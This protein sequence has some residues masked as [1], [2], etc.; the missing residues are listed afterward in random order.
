MSLYP[1]YARLR[2]LI[3]DSTGYHILVDDDVLQKGDETVCGSTLYSG[4]EDWK[5]MD[6]KE[7]SSF[8]G[9]TVGEMNSRA[10]NNEMDVEERMFRR[11]L[12][13]TWKDGVR[14]AIKVV[15]NRQ[16]YYELYRNGDVVKAH[17]AVFAVIGDLLILLKAMLERGQYRS[18]TPVDGG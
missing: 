12:D 4:N 10:C 7:F 18:S 2:E 5:V 13:L 1:K 9:R 3:N 16:Q 8:F 14:D 17:P 11:K 6:E 15:E